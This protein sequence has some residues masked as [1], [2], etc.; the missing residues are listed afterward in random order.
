[1]DNIKKS[2]ME[3]FPE[4]DEKKAELLAK[5]NDDINILITRVLDNNIDP[6]SLDMKEL[7]PGNRTRYIEKKNYNYREAFE[8][9]IDMHVDISYL[10]RQAS[11]LNKEASELLKQGGCH[12]IREARSYYIIEADKRL[13]KAKELNRKAAVVLMRRSLEST[14]A[15]DLH[16]FTIDETVKFMDDLYLFKRFNKIKVITGQK[17][18]SLKIRPAV[19][20]WFKKHGFDC[21]EQGPCVLAIKKPHLSY[22]SNI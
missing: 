8:E 13:E 6:P 12:A 21:Y 3:M 22:Y 18:N 4:L 2:L 7:C 17:Y 1:M 14:D 5:T 9:N 20:E 16:G 10:R 11:T 19:E 15:I